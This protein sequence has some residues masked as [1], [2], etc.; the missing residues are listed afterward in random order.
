M[1]V[2]DELAT[3]QPDRDTGVA[4]G[5]FDGVHLGHKYLLGRLGET[6]A[7]RGLLSVVVTFRQHPRSILSPPTKITYLTSLRERV[8]L[9]KELGIDH[10]ATLSF[11]PEL[12][13]L[14]AH[15]F[16]DLLVRRLRM[17]HLVIGPDFALGR[18]REGDAHRLSA[19]GEEVGFSVEVVQPLVSQG[20]V[21]SSTAIRVALLQG[22]MDKVSRLL[23]RPFA[24]IGEVVRGDERGRTLGFP[25]ANLVPDVE[26][27]IPPD[28]VYAAR[29]FVKGGSFVAVTNIGVRPTFGGG[30]RLLEVHLLDF[31]D[32]ELYGN[33]LRVEVL[34]RL[35]GEVRF[36]SVDELKAQM[37]RDVEQ[38]RAL[39]VP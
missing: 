21:V 17:R 3:V 18:G 22:D 38:T 30:K 26:Q 13:H 15:E 33:E 36:T 10:V 23:G 7:A 2:E 16:V 4:V 29:A 32:G 5:V 11:T 31:Q 8:R 1:L 25:T 37:S 14:R 19:T 24:L 12:S 20:D 39:L 35:R 28:G 27:A 9:L 34:G 6:A